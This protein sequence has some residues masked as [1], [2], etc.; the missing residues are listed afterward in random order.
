MT[1]VCYRLITLPTGPQHG[2][3]H[4]DHPTCQ[5]GPAAQQEEPSTLIHLPEGE[6]ESED[7]PQHRRRRYGVSIIKPPPPPQN[8]LTHPF[9]DMDMATPTIE[10]SSMATMSEKGKKSKMVNMYA[11]FFLLFS[12]FVNFHSLAPHITHPMANQTRQAGR[13]LLPAP[14]KT[15]LQQ[16][17]PRNSHHEFLSFFL[18]FFC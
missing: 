3:Q 18:S 6:K 1:V 16:S 17:T 12:F 13:R 9:S 5:P 2:A 7:G 4:P 10:P 15:N 14:M 8:S 11:V